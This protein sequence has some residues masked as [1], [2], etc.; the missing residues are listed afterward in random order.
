[1]VTVTAY[2]LIGVLASA[3]LG[4]LVARSPI[5]ARAV[6]VGRRASSRSSRPARCCGLPWVHETA[7][8]LQFGELVVPLDLG[9]SRTTAAIAFVVA[10]VTAAVQIYSTWYLASD[11]RQGIFADQALHREEKGVHDDR[12]EAFH[13]LVHE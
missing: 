7:V 8:G 12:G 3:G 2:Q 10:L 6:A 4:L 13:R 5:A 1:V 9:T 11:D